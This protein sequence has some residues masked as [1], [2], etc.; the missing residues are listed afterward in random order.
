MAYG[1]YQGL[2]R[3]LLGQTKYHGRAP[4]A[5]SMGFYLGEWFRHF[6]RPI[7]AI[8]PIPLHAERLN[9]RG[10]NQAEALARGLSEALNSP[11]RP[12]LIR[13]KLTPALHALSLEERRLA[14][15]NCFDTVSER[16]VQ[17]LSGKTLLL[18]DD[19]FTTGATLAEAKKTLPTES[20]LSL[21][22]ARTLKQDS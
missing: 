5:H 7:Q 12:I 18:V 4:L 15:N 11:V 17:K 9:E 1:P 21:T 20:G 8:V 14:L 3:Q 13:K 22:L 16:Q 2:L 19:I 6:N 10:Y